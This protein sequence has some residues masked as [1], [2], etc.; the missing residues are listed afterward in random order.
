MREAKLQITSKHGQTIS[1]NTN[2]WQTFDLL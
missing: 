2:D 1:N